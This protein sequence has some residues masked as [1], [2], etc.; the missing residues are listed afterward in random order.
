MRLFATFRSSWSSSSSVRFMADI[1]DGRGVVAVAGGR[2]VA[3]MFLF[4]PLE[5]PSAGSGVFSGHF[6]SLLS[7]LSISGFPR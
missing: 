7:A 4:E 6:F 3:E 2:R 1:E 5:A